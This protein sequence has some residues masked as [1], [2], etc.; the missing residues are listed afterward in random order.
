MGRLDLLEGAF[1]RQCDLDNLREGHHD[2]AIDTL[3]SMVTDG[4]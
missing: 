2:N 4:M 3:E 1:N